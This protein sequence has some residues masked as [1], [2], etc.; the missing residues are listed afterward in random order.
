VMVHVDPSEE[1]GEE[2]HRVLHHAH[3]GLEPHS[4]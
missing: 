2:F 3:N 4:H 1:A